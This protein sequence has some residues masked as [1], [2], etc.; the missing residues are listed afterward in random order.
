[1]KVDTRHWEGCAAEEFIAYETTDLN[2]RISAERFRYYR[3]GRCGLV[4]LI[5]PPENLSGYYPP[6]YHEFPSLH[7]LGQIA[8]K[9]RC[10]IDTVLKFVQSGKLL[11]IGP[12]Y[13][14]FAYQAK[15]A[16]FDVHTIEM[17]EKCCEYME[18]V[19]GLRVVCSNKPE[20][21]LRKMEKHNVITLWHVIEHLT[22]P[23]EVLRSA[24]EN[25]EAG[26]I[27]VIAAPNPE[28]WQF[29]V[30]GAQWPHLDAPRHLYLFPISLL[31]DYGG[32][33]GLSLEYVT[34]TDADAKSWNRFGWQRWL[35]NR[36]NNRWLERLAYLAGYAVSLAT[37]FLDGREPQGSAYTIV[38]RKD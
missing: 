31:A 22:D 16:G 25:L 6:S 18:D 4:R 7:E 5:N 34:T 33:L 3:C 20:D 10:K 1:M 38:F 12:S 9:S 29:G 23:W 13:G 32:S 2:H 24:S 19:V 15:Q 14:L 11:E 36:V 21:A 17:D 30:M 37:V 28:S 8:D 35:M 26:G 27:L